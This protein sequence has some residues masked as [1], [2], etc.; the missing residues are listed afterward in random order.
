MELLSLNSQLKI[1]SALIEGDMGTD[2]ILIPLS[3]WDSLDLE[4]RKI[5][6]RKLP[7]LL[8]RY[9]KYVASMKRLYWRA[10]KI[11]YNWGV[12]K[13]KKMSIRVNSGAWALLGALAAA[14][15]VSR[16][17]LFNYMLWLDEIGVGDSIVE[18]LNIGV[19]RFHGIYRMIWTLNLE[20]NLISR[21]LEFE[22]NPLQG[23]YP[24][25]F[26]LNTQ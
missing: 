12:G 21:E 18:T 8:R 3:L 22:P 11:K 17:Y 16:C 10:G 4:E 6:S 26:Q 7:Y 9:T 2:S 5:L 25:G 19:P 15:G 13:M 1:E 20:K 23:Y 14:H 24:Y